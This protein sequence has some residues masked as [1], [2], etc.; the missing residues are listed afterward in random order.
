MESRQVW[1]GQSEDLKMEDV[2]ERRMLGTEIDVCRF[3]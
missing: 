2:D 1:S 3:G